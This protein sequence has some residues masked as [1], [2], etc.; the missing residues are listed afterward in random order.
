M[1]Q[2][3]PPVTV[4]RRGAE[5]LAAGHLWVYRTDVEKAAAGVEP[6]DVVA[7]RDGRGRF[8]GKAF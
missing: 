5:R 4:T 1:I 3:E 7:V 8:L 2:L 6:G